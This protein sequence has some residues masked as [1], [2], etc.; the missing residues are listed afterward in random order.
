[1]ELSPGPVTGA[2]PRRAGALLALLAVLLPVCGLLVAGERARD[3]VVER[4]LVGQAA[5]AR[6]VAVQVE[7]AWAQA[8]RQARSEASRPSLQDALASGDVEL[9]QRGLASAAAA[10]PFASLAVHDV[11]GRRLAASGLA[12]PDVPSLPHLPTADRERIG[13]PVVLGADAIV[14][15]VEPVAARGQRVGTLRVRLSFLRLMPD[16]ERMRFGRTGTSSV[17][18]GTGAYL[19]TPDAAVRGRRASSPEGRALAAAH[20]S[21]DLRLYSPRFDAQVVAH[22]APVEHSTLGV[23]TRQF[24]REAFATADRLLVRLRVAAAVALVLGL[25]LLGAGGGLLRHYRRRLAERDAQLRGVVER[26]RDIVARYDARGRA[27]FISPAITGVLGYTEAERLGRDPLELVHPDDRARF[28]EEGR[29]H[30]SEASVTRTFRMVHRDGHDVWVE[31]TSVVDRDADGRTA[32]YD[33]ITRDVTERHAAQV[34]LAEARDQAL[35]ASVS[36]SVFLANTSHELR[37]PLNGILGLTEVLLATPLA[38]EQ[39]RYAQSVHDSGRS[40]LTILDDVL[41]LAKVEAGK[42]E[43]ERLPFSLDGVVARVVA[44]FRALVAA[45]PVRLD[46]EVDDRLPAWVLGDP[47][48]FGQVLGNLVGNA[49][50]FTDS[51]CVSVVVRPGDEPAQVEV[52]VSDTG[53]G[54][55]PEALGR[56]FQSFTQADSSTTRRFGGTGLGLAVSRHLAE[57][58]DG[59]LTVQSRPGQ[60]STFRFALPLPAAV[61]PPAPVTGPDALP[62]P[63]VRLRVL[64][65]EDD[66]VNQLV[67]R[68]MLEQL[69]HEVDVVDDGAAAVD[70]VLQAEPPY[71]VVLMDCQMPV[72]DGW[73]AT[74]SLR[75]GRSPRA[76]TPVFGL[77]AS[78]MAADREQGLAAGMDRYLTKP[79]SRDE[80]AV[81]LAE[82]AAARAAP[83]LART[84]GPASRT[85]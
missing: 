17:V 42:V 72:V 67:A 43:L 49:V 12:L 15:V 4:A 80:L 50:T 5:T 79:I 63:G 44:P 16:L 23:F 55:S 56:L 28:V 14:E 58:Q 9:L 1:M 68:T 21:G 19:L 70:A 51:G 3:A 11:R 33:I 78:A 54:I 71:D 7:H 76:G 20:R 30:R 8:L 73:E 40:L 48:R 52:L 47:T 77:S 32:G 45:K 46:V 27:V 38:A 39:R 57:L 22:Y 84:G 69:G 25:V 61:A 31:V 37:T 36:K 41:D 74:R 34:A 82:L 85:P 62:R 2:A 64:V 13:R 24:E 66:L 81:A 10:G 59:S 35:A 65:A 75:A 60:G 29:R 53:I 18:D 26:S 83:A 6:A